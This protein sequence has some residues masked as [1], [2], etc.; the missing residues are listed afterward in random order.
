MRVLFKA[1]LHGILHYG[2]PHQHYVQPEEVGH[3]IELGPI[4]LLSNA[5]S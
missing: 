2:M 5:H 3:V 1:A 4:E